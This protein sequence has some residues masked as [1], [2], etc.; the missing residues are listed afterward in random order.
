MK[1]SSR[2]LAVHVA[3]WTVVALAVSMAIYGAYQYATVPGISV[4]GLLTEHLAHVVVLGVVIYGVLWLGLQQ[5]IV[6]PSHRVA[7]HLYGVGMGEVEEL[8]VASPV[9]EVQHIVSAVNLM[10]RRMEIRRNDDAIERV[11]RDIDGLA[12][13]AHGLTEEHPLASGKLLASA[14][15]IEKTL[16]GLVPR[17]AETARESTRPVASED[18][19]AP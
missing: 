12:T 8:S 10:I 5:T 6:Q 11:W 3:A 19:L 7:T 14:A 15:R 13:L 9:R 16:L 18:G 1:S 2:S 4:L 17:P